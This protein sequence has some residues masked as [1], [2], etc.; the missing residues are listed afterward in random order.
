M[1]HLTPTKTFRYFLPVAD[2]KNEV[3]Y[4]QDGWRQRLIGRKIMWLNYLATRDERKGGRGAQK[5]NHPTVDPISPHTTPQ[6]TLK[7]EWTGQ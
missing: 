4:P 5:T 3:T 6:T 7:A 2:G 1:V